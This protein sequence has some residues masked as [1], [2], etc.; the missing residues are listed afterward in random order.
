MSSS[1]P[2][3]DFQV[4]AS[5]SRALNVRV[6]NQYSNRTE[7]KLCGLLGQTPQ[8]LITFQPCLE[9]KGVGTHLR[10]LRVEMDV[11]H[12]KVHGGAYL[13]PHRHTLPPPL[14]LPKVQPGKATNISPHLR[15]TNEETVTL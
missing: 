7:R 14:P 2:L 3:G 10:A 8:E 9:Q 5:Y 13:P 11:A 12:T 15:T 4:G 6:D 1:N